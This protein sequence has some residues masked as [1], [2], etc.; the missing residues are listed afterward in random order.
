MRVTATWSGWA[1]IGYGTNSQFGRCTRMTAA[2]LWRAATLWT[3]SR[4]GRPTSVRPTPRI[5]AAA[6]ASFAR[7][8]TEPNGVGSPLVMSTRWTLW[9]CATSL[10]TVPPMP[11]S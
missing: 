8:S 1:S 6:A 11:S 4:L 5:A 9:P 2:T 3:T 10:A 7:V